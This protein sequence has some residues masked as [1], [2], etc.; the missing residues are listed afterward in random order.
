MNTK[1]IIISSSCFNQ[2]DFNQVEEES[3]ESIYLSTSGEQGYLTYTT[4]EMP[5]FISE[6]ASYEGPYTPEDLGVILNNPR[7]DSSITYP[8]TKD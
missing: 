1:H 2:V 3:I 6:V 7:W 5:Q 8:E 4:D